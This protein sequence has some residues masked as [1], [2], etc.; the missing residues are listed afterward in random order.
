MLNILRWIQEGKC[1]KK[2]E[3]ANRRILSFWRYKS[4]FENKREIKPGHQKYS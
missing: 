2:D 3:L 4:R 1:Q